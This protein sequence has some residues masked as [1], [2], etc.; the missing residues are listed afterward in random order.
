MTNAVPLKI[1]QPETQEKRLTLESMLVQIGCNN[2][3]KQVKQIQNC[4]QKN[5]NMCVFGIQTGMYI[6]PN[7]GTLVTVN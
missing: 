5:V 7:S 6:A 4:K 2:A 1:S 3:L